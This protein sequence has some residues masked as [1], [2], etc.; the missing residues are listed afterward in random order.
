MNG[1]MRIGPP[2]GHS[3]ALRLCWLWLPAVL[4]FFPLAAPAQPDTEG[5]PDLTPRAFE[6]RGDL[7]ISLPNL[8]RQPLRGFAPPPRTYVVPGSRQAYVAPYAQRLDNLPAD[9]LAQPAPPEVA[10]LAPLAG[11]IDAGFGRYLSRLGRFTLSTGGLGV[12]LNYSG[13]SD[14]VPFGGVAEGQDDIDAE[15]DAF[16]GHIAYTTPGPT[17]F[18]F[19]L[20]GDYQRYALIGAVPRRTIPERTSRT[21][22]GSASLSSSVP[23]RVPYGLDVRFASTDIAIDAD[24]DATTLPDDALGLTETRL[25]ASGHATLRR[26]R[27]DAAGALAGLGDEGLGESLTTYSAGGALRLDVGRGRLDVGARFLGYSASALNG[28][29]SSVNVGPVVDGELPIS[30]STR[31]FLRNDPH[32]ER[33]GLAGLARENPYAVPEPFVAPGLNVIDG[34]AG[35]EVQGRT[36][37]LRAFGAARYS[38]VFLYFERVATGETAG[39]YEARYDEAVVFGGGGALTLYAPNGFRVTAEAEARAGSLLDGNRD[40]PYFAPVVGRLSLAMPFAGE[41]GLVQVT[42]TAESARPTEDDGEDAPAW[43]SLDAEA[44]YL[45]TPSFG[46]LLRADRL[47]GR[48]E[49]WPGFPRPP[50]TVLAG[51]RV[52]W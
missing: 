37:R 27:F 29:G 26:L 36:V 42:G 6:I 47:A 8:E 17:R 52:R 39:L 50:A 32:V 10:T 44:H 9:P 49:Q 43:A 28:D 41:R 16:A 24:E 51:L 20:D 23:G 7:Q 14:F 2:R 34:E 11:R 45:F 33:R 3:E 30:P 1:T 15:A 18:G 5:L 46:V 13:Y 22:G 38:P 31:L 4:L 19:S 40:I 21:I 35:V 48:A 12:N 25:E